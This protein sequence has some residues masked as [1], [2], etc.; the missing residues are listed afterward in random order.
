MKAPSTWHPAK[1]RYLFSSPKTESAEKNSEA[2]PTHQSR[3]H[4]QRATTTKKNKHRTARCVWQWWFLSPPCHHRCRRHQPG[5]RWR[6]ARNP[7]PSL[8]SVWPSFFH[9]MMVL[10][11]EC[12]CCCYSSICHNTRWSGN[13]ER[14]VKL[15]IWA[16]AGAFFGEIRRL[17]KKGARWRWT[18]STWLDVVEFRPNGLLLDEEIECLP[19]FFWCF[20]L[21]FRYR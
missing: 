4:S 20:L 11:L 2:N 21:F 1:W 13:K 16:M 14:W 17:S 6:R 10:A 8:F 5:S 7:W 18:K 3:S 12:W 15:F 19:A 9:L